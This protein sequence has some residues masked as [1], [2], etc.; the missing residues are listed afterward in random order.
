M[1]HNNQNWD[2]L[3]RDIQNVVDQAVNSRDYQ[4]LN[5][6]V[7]QVV[8]QAVDSGSEAAQ[9]L[10]DSTNQQN[11][12]KLYARTIGKM[13]K[14]MLQYFSG[15]PLIL[16]SYL[17]IIGNRV[18]ENPVPEDS[19][20][21]ICLELVLAIGGLLTVSAIMNHRMI[22]RF[23][24]Y[25]RRI[26][27]KTYCSVEELAHSV[28]KKKEFVQKDLRRMISKGFFPEGHL[29]KEENTLI[30]SHETYHYYE[31]CGQ[32]W[33]E[34]KQQETV[35]KAQKTP[36][37][38]D[39][40][41]QDV[42]DRG[43]AFIAQIRKCND[44]IP[45]E[46]ISEKISCIELLIQRIFN[47]AKT[48]PEIIPDLKKLMDYY[49]PM[50]VKLLTAYAEMDAQPVQGET[51]E[52]SKREIEATLDTLN[53]A[54]EKL[55]DDLFEDTALDVSSDISVLNTL[56]AQEGLTDDEFLKRKEQQNL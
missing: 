17:A 33:E 48:H 10:L 1:A 44:D 38:L 26:G 7:R 34:I 23:K 9:R 45:G 5:Q 31:Q 24:S 27:Q 4:Q 39:P 37:S 30:I 40:Q 29:D 49:L 35:V 51:I 11:G 36:S 2:S 8:A 28:G 13:A 16:L 54:F 14:V 41:V 55:L 12:K 50:T 21:I 22:Q 15:I 19:P 47:R 3:G 52:N 42:L 32:Q 46:V 43:E 25:K 20:A 56:L 6:T 18:S 53:A